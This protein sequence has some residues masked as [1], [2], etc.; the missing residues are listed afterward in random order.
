MANY[1]TQTF[2]HERARQGRGKCEWLT[3]PELIRALG[4]FDLDPCAPAA[5][6][7]DMAKE[8]YTIADD[9]LSRP[10]FGRVWLNPPYGIETPKWMSRLARH[11]NGI[12]LVFARTETRTFFE[13]VWR[14]ADAVMFLKGRLTFYNADGTKPDN[15]GGAP[16]CLVAYGRANMAAL[17]VSGLEGQI[18]VA[19]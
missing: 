3:P 2:S 16:S 12:A 19:I 13:S 11:G 9:G 14:V 7:W 15:T 8:H 4:V 18:V 1:V 5:R 6:P 17:L 10:W